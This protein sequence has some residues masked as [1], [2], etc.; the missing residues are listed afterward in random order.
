MI[1]NLAILITFGAGIYF[2]I[3]GWTYFYKHDFKGEK[4]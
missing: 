2:L 1:R 3:K 4:K